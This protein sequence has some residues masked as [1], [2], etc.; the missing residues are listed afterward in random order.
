MVCNSKEL[1]ELANL[2]ENTNY[3]ALEYLEALKKLKGVRLLPYSTIGNEG[4]I[5][6]FS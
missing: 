3:N 4:I 6:V 1:C 2:Q 5:P